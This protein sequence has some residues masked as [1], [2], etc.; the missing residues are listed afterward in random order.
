VLVW[1]RAF[2]QVSFCRS[3]IWPRLVQ[4]QQTV[5][6]HRRDI[7]TVSRLVRSASAQETCLSKVKYQWNQS[8]SKTDTIFQ[9]YPNAIAGC[10]HVF[11]DR[12]ICT[13]RILKAI[14]FHRYFAVYHIFP[15]N[16]ILQ[17]LSGN[18]L[19]KASFCYI[20]FRRVITRWSI[21]IKIKKKKTHRHPRLLW[22]TATRY[23]P[24]AA[25]T[26]PVPSIMP[27]NESRAWTIAIASLHQT[28]DGILWTLCKTSFRKFWF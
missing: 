16:I 14:A 28:V 25:P 27:E 2:F 5:A 18:T 6:G 17:L 4:L 10:L 24:M 21:T 1:P 13:F 12:Q 23:W 22:M 26:L 8:S 7:L 20:G 19:S 15:F 11:L 3:G 9:L